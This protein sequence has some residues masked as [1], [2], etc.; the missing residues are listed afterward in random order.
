MIAVVFDG[1]KMVELKEKRIEYSRVGDTI[2]GSVTFDSDM[3][4]KTAEAF[5]WDTDE[6]MLSCCETEIFK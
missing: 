2:S 5:I 6:T 3:S 4:G 1:D